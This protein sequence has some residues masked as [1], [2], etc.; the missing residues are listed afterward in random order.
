MIENF[1]EF[2]LTSEQDNAFVSVEKCE[3]E[4]RK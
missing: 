2:V 3:K 4:K 1:Y